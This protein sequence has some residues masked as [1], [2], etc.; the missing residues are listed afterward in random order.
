VA[1]RCSARRSPIGQL[2]DQYKKQIADKSL[3]IEAADTIGDEVAIAKE[4]RVDALWA[5]VPFDDGAL[6]G[7]RRVM[8]SLIEGKRAWIP[9]SPA[10]TS[11]R[12]PTAD[13]VHPE[14]SRAPARR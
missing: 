13:T 11:A 10:S 9:S 5:S 6:Q 12:R 3:T 7:L 8:I 14:V 1:G 4:G 2:T